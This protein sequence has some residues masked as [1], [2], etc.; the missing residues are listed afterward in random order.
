MPARASAASTP[1][2]RGPGAGRRGHV[3]AAVP[4]RPGR[5][6]SAA[7]RSGTRE[8]VRDAI[9]AARAA[10]PAWAARGWT[11]RLTLLRR[12]AE[13]ISER[14][15]EYAALMAIE[16]GKNRVEALGEVEESADL[17]RYY[18]QTAERRGPT[19]NGPWTTLGDASTRT[20]SVLRPH[21]V[22]AVISPFNFP[23]GALDRAGG[24]GAHGRQHGRLQARERRCDERDRADGGVPRRRPA[25]RGHQP[26]DGPRRHRG[27]RA[28]GQRRDRRHRLHRLIRGRDGPPPRVHARLPASMHRGDGRQ[29]P[30]ARHAQRGPR[31]SRA[32]ASCAPPSASAARNA[33]PTAASTCISSVH[34]EL[35]R[36]LVA[37][38]E[39]ITHR[40]PARARALARPGHRRSGASTRFRGCRGGCPPR[41]DR[42][43]RRRAPVGRWP[44]ARLLRRAHGRRAAAGR[45]PA[46]PRRAVRA[47]HGDPCRRLDRRGAGALERV[48]VRADRGHLQR[49]TRARWTT[50]ST[51]SRRACST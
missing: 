15:M 29:E 26:R 45:P 31:R 17:I 48:R 21:G 33:R 7:S 24:R 32:K 4:D 5:S 11:E 18:A 12:A 37:K 9:A 30:R 28:G 35:V 36:L 13:L 8:D 14:Q 47:V 23:H 10:Q 51:A 20:R 41:W 49:R 38:S 1:T 50:S 27:R 34:D 43:H 22:F 25:R 16:V 39:A 6:S 40:R 3:R 19:S 44:R 2:H 46:L 42:V